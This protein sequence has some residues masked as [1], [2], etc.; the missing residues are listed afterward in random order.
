MIELSPGRWRGLQAS[1]HSPTK[2]AREGGGVFGIVA[3]DQR[4]SYRK[5]MPHA[6]GGWRHLA[7]VKREISQ[8]LS[9]SASAVLLDP[10]YGLP[11]A[12]H[13]SGRAGLLMA[14]EQSGYQGDSHSRQSQLLPGWTPAKIRRLGANAVKLMVYYHPQHPLAAETERF[15]T[16]VVADCHR[17][18]L[19]VFL[20]P[21]SYSIQPDISKGSRVFAGHR[22]EIVIETAQR[23]SET[24]ADVLKLEFP[25]DIQHDTDETS[26]RRA[27][28]RLSEVCA[29][30][31][32]LLSAGVDFE[33]FKPQLEVACQSGA[34]GFL[35]G[36]AIW[37]EAVVMSA[38]ER[39]D[40]LREVA[41][42]RLHQLLWI[43]EREARPWTDFYQPPA[44]CERFFESY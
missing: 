9:Q 26:W 42:P 12:M 11:A 37:K 20:E 15:V 21:M 10:V 17:Q 41:R 29:V 40:F 7:A 34:S 3:F 39:A 32:V 14:L 18:D 6:L 33:Q 16:E 22:S 4:S 43:A 44:F 5:M 19:P 1:S 38:A 35:A 24:G 23:L 28:T 13:M 36:R 30:P 27:C 2:K 31:W 8:A 25:V